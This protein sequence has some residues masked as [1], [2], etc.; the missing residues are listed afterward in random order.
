MKTRPLTKEETQEIYKA[1]DQTAGKILRVVSDEYKHI[2]GIIIIG[3]RDDNSFLQT[4]FGQVTFS[5]MLEAFEKTLH[6]Y[7]KELPEEK[8]KDAT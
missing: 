7:Y 8:L 5:E 3:I 2:R 6:S 1:I 4:N